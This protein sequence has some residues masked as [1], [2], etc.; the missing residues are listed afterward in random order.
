MKVTLHFT[1][2]QGTI[3]ANLESDAAAAGTGPDGTPVGGTSTTGE[4]K[5]SPG[6][7]SIPLIAVLGVALELASRRRA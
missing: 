2:F 5:S 4:K 3:S 1:G 7:E 6:F